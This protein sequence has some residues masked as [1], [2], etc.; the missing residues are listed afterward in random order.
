MPPQSPP[1]PPFPRPAEDNEF[2]DAVARM[3]ERRQR[4]A[5]DFAPSPRGKTVHDDVDRWVSPGASWLS[6]L[7]AALALRRVLLLVPLAVIGY[8]IA[9][10]LYLQP[11]NVTA[12]PVDET[13]QEAA[14]V[15]A[16]PL[17]QS[18]SPPTEAAESKAAPAEV[19]T[20]PAAAVPVAS[21]TPGKASVAVDPPRS[22]TKD[23]IK[24]LQGK[25]TEA[26]FNAGP[27]DGVV[28][29]QTEAALRRYAQAR[30]LAKPEANR[31]TL[32]LLR[33]ETK[34]KP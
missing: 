6:S 19:V 24:E 33:S 5:P 27:V 3:F 34:A 12:G 18:P 9:W 4:L 32:L 17:Q 21:A 22:L 1:Q 14:Q 15:V 23:E 31:E 29:P 16:A 10:F 8:A 7:S 13:R 28:G 26:G 2:A 30:S 20:T 11:E 25:L